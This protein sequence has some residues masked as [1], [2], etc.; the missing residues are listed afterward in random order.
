WIVATLMAG[1]VAGLTGPHLARWVR[2]WFTPPPVSFP[3]TEY[4][5]IDPEAPGSET[6]GYFE[7]AE[8]PLR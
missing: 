4:E 7:S 1:I 3:T 6:T 2:R 5:S 8:S